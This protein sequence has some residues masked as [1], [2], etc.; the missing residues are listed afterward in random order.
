M[1]GQNELDFGG[2]V[3]IVT[4]AGQGM[5]RAHAIMLA[6]RGA[7]VVANDIAGDRAG[8][9]V[10]MI[11]D[12]G[13]T[14]VLDSNDIVTRSADLVQTA[15]TNFGRL[16]IVVNNAG[17]NKF[18]RFWEMDP[19]VWWRV[20]DTSFKGLVEVSR[21]AM[22]HLIESGTGRL[23]NI[24]SNA[25][26][27]LANDSSYGAA[28]AAIWGLSN[29]LIPEARDVGVQ[30][31]TLLPVAWTPMTDDAFSD[32]LIRK[33]MVEQFPSSAVSA[34]VTWLAHQDTTVYGES[35]EIG[36]ASAARTVFAAMPRL[37]IT[38][39]TPEEWAVNAAT[40]LQDGDLTPLYQASDSFRAQVVNLVPEMDAVLPKDAANVSSN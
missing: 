23:I 33:I 1:A 6:S 38:E 34:F 30:V 36:G 13:G 11:T 37:T 2:R 19:D 26:M 4:G 7:R 17:I 14:A 12:A 10:Q 29:S 16:D 39:A 15:I 25:L 18:G 8:E 40:L 21:H 20:F 3:A 31:S 28:K 32:P 27:G 22:P 24:A 9:T 5:G 35:F